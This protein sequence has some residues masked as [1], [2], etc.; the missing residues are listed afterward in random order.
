LRP[1]LPL[2]ARTLVRAGD[3]PTAAEQ[4]KATGKY[5]LFDDLAA[6]LVGEKRRHQLS[7][8]R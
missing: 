2:R 3:D 8:A 7:T 1:K 4:W 5:D 6:T